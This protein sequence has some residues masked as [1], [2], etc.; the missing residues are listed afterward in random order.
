MKK[1]AGILLI[2]ILTLVV[3]TI[4][5]LSPIDIETS[6]EVYPYEEHPEW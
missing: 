3:L 2:S 4:S 5:F 1:K 6:G